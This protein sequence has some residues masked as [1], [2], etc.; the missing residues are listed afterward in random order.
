MGANERTGMVFELT[1]DGDKRSAGFG[2]MPAIWFSTQQLPPAPPTPPPAPVPPTPQPALGMVKCSASDKRQQWELLYDSTKSMAAVKSVTAGACM[3]I[4]G[5]SADDH[6][7]GDTDFGCKALPDP[8]TAQPC[9]KNMAW[10]FNANGTITSVLSG[11]CLQTSQRIEVTT[12]DGSTAQTWA[13]HDAGGGACTIREA[14]APGRCLAEVLLTE[15]APEQ[16]RVPS[17]VNVFYA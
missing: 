6:A 8:D 13:L 10:E 9:D 3:E 12:C 4:R 17:S 5:C 2:D 7:K 16:G 1:S 11:K 15:V 14:G